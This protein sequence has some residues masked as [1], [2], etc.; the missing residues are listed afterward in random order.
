M[1]LPLVLIDWHEFGQ[2][3]L[4]DTNLFNGYSIAVNISLQISEIGMIFRF[5]LCFVFYDCNIYDCKY[6]F[7]LEYV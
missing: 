3:K 6:I 2:V 1:V 7:F 5:S 4:L